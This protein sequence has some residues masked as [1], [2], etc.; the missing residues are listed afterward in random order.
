MNPNERVCEQVLY[1]VLYFKYSRNLEKSRLVVGWVSELF[2]RGEIW[3][4]KDLGEAF[5]AERTGNVSAIGFLF[6]IL[7]YHTKSLG[8]GPDTSE[9]ESRL[10]H[11]SQP[12]YH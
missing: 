2:G 5:C 9:S 7:W 12:A 4:I 6:A 1:E 10:H 8:F 11:L 3:S